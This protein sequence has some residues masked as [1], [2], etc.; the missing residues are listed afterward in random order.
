MFNYVVKETSKNGTKTIIVP[1]GHDLM[2]DLAQIDR[3]HKNTANKVDTRTVNTRE[4]KTDSFFTEFHQVNTLWIFDG[5][6]KSRLFQG[7]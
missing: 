1:G 6:V 3:S 4:R 5:H 2:W 7:D